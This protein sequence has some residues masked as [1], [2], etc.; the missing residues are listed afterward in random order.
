MA[1]A[2]IRSFERSFSSDR[3]S[4]SL[5]RKRRLRRIRAIEKRALL[6]AVAL[7]F[8]N[9]FSHFALRKRENNHKNNLLSST[10]HTCMRRHTLA[11]SSA[12]HLSSQTEDLK[13]KLNKHVNKIRQNSALSAI[14]FL[15]FV[16]KSHPLLNYKYI[17]SERTAMEPRFRHKPYLRRRSGIRSS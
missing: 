16:T 17:R 11:H 6:V 12:K 2:H 10:Q 7:A 4:L 5:Q 15:P 1:S 9:T 3:V 14:Y 8:S 13:F